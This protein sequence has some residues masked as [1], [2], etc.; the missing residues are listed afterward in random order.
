MKKT[1][2]LLLLLPLLHGACLAQDLQA[3]QRQM[4][5]SVREVTADA[6]NGSLVESAGQSL[7]HKGVSAF[8]V[9]L[10]DSCKASLVILAVCALLGLGEVRRA[11]SCPP[12]PYPSPGSVPSRPSPWP[13]QAAWSPPAVHRWRK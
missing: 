7:L 4:P 5:A 9:H 13:A 10:Q 11:S 1:L 12:I 8:R 3:L 6:E 2:W